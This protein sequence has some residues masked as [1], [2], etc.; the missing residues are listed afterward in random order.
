MSEAPSNFQDLLNTNA[1]DAV[2]PPARPGGTYRATLKAA[3]DTLSSKKRTPGLE[4]NFTDLEPLSDVDTAAYEAYCASPAVKI[5]EDSMSDSFWL[6][7]KSLYRLREFCEACG[8]AAKGKTI[9]QMVGDSIGARVLLT[10]TQNV[11]DKGTY[12]Q[13][14]GYA[15]DE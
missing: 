1:E 12:S 8:V 2:R 4:M 13:I 14:S 10:V 3:A 11:G 6:T 15:L 5:E 9:L 7:T